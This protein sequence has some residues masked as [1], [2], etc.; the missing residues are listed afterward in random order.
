MWLRHLSVKCSINWKLLSH[1]GPEAFVQLSLFGYIHMLAIA[2]L[3]HK[4]YCVREISPSEG[5][6]NYQCPHF[7]HCIVTIC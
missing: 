3:L 7:M 4:W 6:K 2:T 1:I 5:K